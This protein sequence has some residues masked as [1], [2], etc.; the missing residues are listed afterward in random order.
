MTEELSSSL[1]HAVV[2][3]KN[4][5]KSMNQSK[6]KKILII[7]EENVPVFLETND[8]SKYQSEAINVWSKNFHLFGVNEWIK[9]QAG[10]I[11]Y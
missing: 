1:V 4:S 3:Q 9:Y 5:K 7:I 2:N 11:I 10:N 8:L 6:T